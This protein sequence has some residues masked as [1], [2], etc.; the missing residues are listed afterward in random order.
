MPCP[1]INNIPGSA[2]IPASY[3]KWLESAGAIPVPVP[4]HLNTKQLEVFFQNLDGLLIT[5][6]R[7]LLLVEDKPKNETQSGR[8][9]ETEQKNGPPVNDTL[10]KSILHDKSENAEH[11]KTTEQDLSEISDVENDTESSDDENNGENK[12]KDSQDE[13]DSEANDGGIQSSYRKKISKFGKAIKFFV[14]RAMKEKD[15]GGYFPILGI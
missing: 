3:V 14:K 5:G 4:F 7:A 8:V 13:T 2:I 9:N 12:V 15:K 1:V 6:G 10:Q 11:E